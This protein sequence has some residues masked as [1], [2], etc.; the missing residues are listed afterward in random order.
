MNPAGRQEEALALAE[1]PVTAAAAAEVEA[2]EMGWEDAADPG[3]PRDDAMAHGG[4]GSDGE[5]AGGLAAYAAGE[6]AAGP[7]AGADDQQVGVFNVPIETCGR[8]KL[9]NRLQCSFFPPGQRATEGVQLPA[10]R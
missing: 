7:A 9:P 1:A 2:A 5:E 10:P 3:S 6:D 4:G 8:N